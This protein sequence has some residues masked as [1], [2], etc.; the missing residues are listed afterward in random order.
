MLVMAFL[1]GEE[2]RAITGGVI[3]ADCGVGVR[4]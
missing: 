3:D 2:S 4:F 1:L